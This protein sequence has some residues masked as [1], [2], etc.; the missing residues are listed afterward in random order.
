MSKLSPRME[1]GRGPRRKRRGMLYMQHHGVCATMTKYFK[2]TAIVDTEIYESEA[3]EKLF[4]MIM[5]PDD[6]L[7]HFNIEQIEGEDLE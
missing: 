7:E 5:K 4:N 6:I 1:K 2:F 3:V